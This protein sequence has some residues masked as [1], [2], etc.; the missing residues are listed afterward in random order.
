MLKFPFGDFG[1]ATQVEGIESGEFG[2]ML[3]NQGGEAAEEGL[4]T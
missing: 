2:D 4:T 1:G 3:T